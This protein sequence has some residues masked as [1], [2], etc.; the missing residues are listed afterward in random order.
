MNSDAWQHWYSRKEGTIEPEIPK[1]VELLGENVTSKILDL[2]CGAGR[3]VVYLARKGFD[4]YGFDASEAAIE[5]AQEILKTENLFADLRVWDMTRRLPYED[6]FFDAV[7]ALRV[8]HHTY[9][10][11]INR[12]FKEIDRVLKEGGFLFM[13]VPA[14]S[15]GET[16]KW[17]QEDLK[18]TEPEPRTYV[19]SSG[20]EKG[21]PHHIF[22]KKELLRLFENYNI[23]EIHWATE[24]YRGYCLIAKKTSQ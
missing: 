18:R 2:G 20:D 4:V 8:V 10:A 16:L 13:Q 22:T 23:E 15:R 11:N 6:G 19:Y 7:L 21:I 5:H 9:V 12:I 14:F 17:E 1:L 3:H 24:H